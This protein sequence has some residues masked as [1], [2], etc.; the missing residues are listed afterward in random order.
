M[1]V[2]T[3][4]V[5]FSGLWWSG[6]CDSDLHLTACLCLTACQPDCNCAYTTSSASAQ[7]DMLKL[8]NE[9]ISLYTVDSIRRVATECIVPMITQVLRLYIFCAVDRGANPTCNDSVY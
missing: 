9:L 4:I 8:R 7:F 3:V 5:T 6:P 1:C 2:R